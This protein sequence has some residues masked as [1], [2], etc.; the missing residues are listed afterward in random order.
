M[1]SP[2]RSAIQPSAATGSRA[3]SRRRTAPREPASFDHPRGSGRAA[4][5]RRYGTGAPTS[6]GAADLEDAPVRVRGHELPDPLEA[7]AP[8]GVGLERPRIGS[9]LKQLLQ[10]SFVAAAPERARDP[11]GQRIGADTGDLVR[12]TQERHPPQ[13]RSNRAPGG[14]RGA[15][16]ARY[17]TAASSSIAGTSPHNSSS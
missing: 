5:G 13:R 9:L 17:E 7:S 2:R 6:F 15:P 3:A 10:P 8:L 12:F 11:L 1:T 14:H 16:G 4:R